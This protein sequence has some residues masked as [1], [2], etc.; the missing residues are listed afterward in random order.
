[1]RRAHPVRQAAIYLQR[2]LSHELRSGKRRAPHRNDLV[3]IPMQNED[4]SFDR[5]QVR[6][7]VCLGKRSDAVVMGLDPTHHALSPPVADDALRK[8]RAVAVKSVEGA[9]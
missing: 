1:M 2:A 4:W 8:L 7:E 3:F 6:R 9:A 5:L